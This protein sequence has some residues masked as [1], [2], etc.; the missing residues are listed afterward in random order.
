MGEGV[1]LVRE[2]DAGDLHVR[3]DERDVETEHYGGGIGLA[4]TLVATT[5]ELDHGHRAT[6]SVS[7]G[8]GCTRTSAA[9]SVT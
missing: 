7:T 9:G 5:D 4:P 6:S 8:F 3:F 2:P 1:S